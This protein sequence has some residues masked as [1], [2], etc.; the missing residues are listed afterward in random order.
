[1]SLSAHAAQ[2][3]AAVGRPPTAGGWPLFRAKAS[4][5]G[6]GGNYGNLERI[7]FSEIP[8]SELQLSEPRIVRMLVNQLSACGQKLA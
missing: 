6:E 1:M 7:S 8:D 2:K 3:R 5:V 4:L